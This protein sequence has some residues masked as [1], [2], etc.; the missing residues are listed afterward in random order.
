MRV[1]NLSRKQTTYAAGGILLSALI[2]VAE[3]R[4]GPSVPFLTMYF[5]PVIWTNWMV[6]WEAALAI[7]CLD[8]LVWTL[9]FHFEP[10]RHP[11][12]WPPA[13][14]WVRGIVFLTVAYMLSTF[15]R[16]ADLERKWAFEDPLT[17]VA[18]RR[19]FFHWATQEIS[20]AR[21]SGHP[22]TLA[23]VD[24]DDFKHIN[25]RW[26]HAHGD[27]VLVW[28]AKTF[29]SHLRSSDLLARLG[30]DELVILLREDAATGAQAVMQKVHG[31]LQ[32]ASRELGVAVSVSIG[33]ATFE[34]APP[35]VEDMLRAADR[36]MY[37]VKQ[38]G[39]NNLEYYVVKN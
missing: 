28:I 24:V 9:I 32:A 22:L 20:R 15:K 7:A 1:L 14:N 33:V 6:G 18:N 8:V 26:G 23:L 38:K 21:R 27:K 17:G 3:W 2:C 19:A 35:T 39:K 13:W 31:A 29:Q 10:S 11:S 37:H 34:T 25:D 16:M 4:L 36:Q 30:G 5:I 12:A